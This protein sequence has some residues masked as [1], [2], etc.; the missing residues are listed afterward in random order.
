MKRSWLFVPGDDASKIGKALASAADAVILD[1]EDAVGPTLERKAKARA[2]TREYLAAHPEQRARCF[3]RINGLAPEFTKADLPVA[4]EGGAAGVVL[5]KCEGPADVKQLSAM[6]DAMET[7][8]GGETGRTA[9]IA[10]VTETARG[11]Q[12]LPDF[13]DPL[14]RLAGLMWGAEDLNADL[15]GTTNRDAETGAYL[16]PYT[17]ARDACLIAARAVGVSAIDAVYPDFRDLDGL[18]R[19]ARAHRALGFDSKA[20]IHPAQ[21]SVIAEA[22]APTA[23]D[24]AWAERVI[25]AFG[26]DAGVVQLDGVM[27]DVPH[28]RRARQILS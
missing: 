26:Q 3:V 8:L 2:V 12:C 28:L 19:E 10:I 14:W 6:L 4:L 23:A 22:F 11:L 9:I 15:A 18:G 5:P 20:A 21:L 27:L 24:R 17:H 7:K 16:S 13:R 1:L 25:A